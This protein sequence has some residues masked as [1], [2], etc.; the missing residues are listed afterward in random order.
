MFCRISRRNKHPNRYFKHAQNWSQ[1]FFLGWNLLWGMLCEDG[2]WRV[3]KYIFEC[4]INNTLPLIF[5]GLQKAIP[6]VMVRKMQFLKKFKDVYVWLN[7]PFD[8][9]SHC[10]TNNQV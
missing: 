10:T 8:E 4:A 6:V 7:L 3:Y 2:N 5:M 1:C 9:G